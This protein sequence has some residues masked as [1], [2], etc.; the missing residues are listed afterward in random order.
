MADSYSKDNK[1]SSKD[2]KI[3]LDATRKAIRAIR[4]RRIKES[5]LHFVS[6]AEACL[7]HQEIHWASD[8]VRTVVTTVVALNRSI[9]PEV[10][11]GIL[12]GL[13]EDSE[14][15]ATALRRAL[16]FTKSQNARCDIKS[17][18]P[19]GSSS[20]VSARNSS[21]YVLDGGS[22]CGSSSGGGFTG[23]QFVW[24]AALNRK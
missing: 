12:D 11:V 9:S 16:G 4:D 5:L 13:L 10:I 20:C 22:G 7:E 2:N 3:S 23:F 21:C 1:I 17:G 15:K 19:I 14:T 24:E 18:T 8:C 6:G